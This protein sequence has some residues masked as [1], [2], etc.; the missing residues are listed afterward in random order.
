MVYSCLLTP[1]A[2]IHWFLVQILHGNTALTHVSLV[3]G[4]AFTDSA[5]CQAR[6]RLPLAVFQT[7]LRELVKGRWGPPVPQVP[8]SGWPL[9]RLCAR[10][11]VA[12]SAPPLSRQSQEPPSKELRYCRLRHDGCGGAIHVSQVPESGCLRAPVNG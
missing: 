3:A 5:F 9:P 2:I 7:V 10:K 11:L 6:A 4:R 1:A 8:E 12:P